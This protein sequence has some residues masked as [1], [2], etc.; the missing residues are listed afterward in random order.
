MQTWQHPGL[1]WERSAGVS[2]YMSYRVQLS[3]AIMSSQAFLGETSTPIT[4]KNCMGTLMAKGL[5]EGLIK[6]ACLMSIRVLGSIK[7]NMI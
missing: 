7:G 2:E 3:A 5:K 6:A 1:P 4:L